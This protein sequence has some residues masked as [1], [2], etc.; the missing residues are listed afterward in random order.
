MNR[1]LL[2][3]FFFTIFRIQARRRI[4][5]KHHKNYFYPK[6]AR[7]LNP[8]LLKAQIE[9][10]LVVTALTPQVINPNLEVNT[11]GDIQTSDT[12]TPPLVEEV[13]DKFVGGGGGAPGLPFIV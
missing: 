1:K 2:I 5:H 11:F 9:A 12:S 10:P 6:L 7:F 3:I 4:H 13:D 8:A